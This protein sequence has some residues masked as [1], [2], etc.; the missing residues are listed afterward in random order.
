[1]NCCSLRFV[2][3]LSVECLN[4]V[5]LSST[6]TKRQHGTVQFLLATVAVPLRTFWEIRLL[7]Q[8]NQEAVTWSERTEL[9]IDRSVVHTSRLKLRSSILSPKWFAGNQSARIILRY[10]S[11]GGIGRR[12]PDV[13]WSSVLNSHWG[14]NHWPAVD[15]QY[16]SSLQSTADYDIRMRPE[17]ARSCNPIDATANKYRCLYNGFRRCLYD[18]HAV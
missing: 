18:G 12:L 11:E 13:I 14:L 6:V 3:C 2:G 5:F 4:L 16:E 8:V 17:V 10:K 7:F 9:S 15:Q 1:M